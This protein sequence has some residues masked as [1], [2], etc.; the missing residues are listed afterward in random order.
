MVQRRLRVLAP[1]K[2][3]GRLGGEAGGSERTGAELEAGGAG[4]IMNA[5]AD[6][7]SHLVD[8]P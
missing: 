6:V 3:G 7:G 8:L 1:A 2:L 4:L 5:C